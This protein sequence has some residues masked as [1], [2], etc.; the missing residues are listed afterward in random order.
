MAG[1]LEGIRVI[2]LSML[3]PG[4][5]C[6]QHLADLG[7]WVLKIENPRVPDMTR[8]WSLDAQSAERTSAGHEEEAA[9]PA[10]KDGPM[11]QMLNRNKKSITLNIMRPEGKEILLKL[12]ETADVL[13]EGFRPG[14]MEELGVGYS[15][16]KSRFPRLVYC[17]ISGYGASGPLRDH[18]GH[19]GNYIARAGV[20][21]LT[22]TKQQPVVPGIQIADIAGGTLIA[23]SGI[24]AA[25]FARTRTGEGQFVDVSMMDGAFSLLP[26]IAAEVA[27]GGRPER[28]RMPLSGALPNYNVY[29]TK[30]DRH[31]M[32]GALEERF[33]R[34]FLRQTG[35]EDWME[36]WAAR[37]MDELFSRMEELFAS[38]TLAEWSPLFEN[39]E[40]CL[41]PVNR[42]EEAFS[43]P[44]LV[45][46][47]MALA[48]PEGPRIGSPF[49]LSGTPADTARNAPPGHGEHTKE[50]LSGLGFSDLDIVQLQKKRII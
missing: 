19:D 32:L 5:L 9:G 49:C 33:Y 27:A 8:L 28:A 11:F 30:D 26:L 20:L 13:L 50:I 18:A 4:P 24:L 48:T 10:K 34:S 3:L 38:K 40:C 45:S 37:R 25:L 16:L 12:L 14:K 6:S 43:D 42:L 21:D 7:A 23:L 35:H 15:Q 44:Q 2:D 29:R 31:I 47:G 1:P 41:A 39:T 36:L 46:R 22:G 17:A